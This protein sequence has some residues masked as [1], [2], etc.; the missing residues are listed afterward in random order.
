[1]IFVNFCGEVKNIKTPKTLVLVFKE[2]FTKLINFF[3]TKMVIG[4]VEYYY[5]RNECFPSYQAKENDRNCI[6]IFIE[7]GLQDMDTHS[8]KNI[9][10]QRWKWEFKVFMLPIVKQNINKDHH[11]FTSFLYFSYPNLV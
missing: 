4:K 8:D 6:V 5:S 9:F 2:L 11:L 7:T 3:K 1:M 10:I